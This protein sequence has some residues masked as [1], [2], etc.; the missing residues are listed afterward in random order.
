MEILPIELNIYNDAGRSNFITT[1]SAAPGDIIL[2]RK[3][4]CKIESYGTT[5]CIN[6]LEGRRFF[7]LTMVALVSVYL[8]NIVK[9][10]R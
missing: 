5:K 8:T 1:R 3:T 6:A 2:S 4:R 10:K 7:T 9:K